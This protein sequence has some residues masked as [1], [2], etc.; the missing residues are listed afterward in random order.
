MAFSVVQ[1]ISA[2]KMGISGSVKAMMIADCQSASRIVPPTRNG[3]VTANPSWGR[4][5]LK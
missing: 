2:M 5:L 3:T 1:P 4:Y